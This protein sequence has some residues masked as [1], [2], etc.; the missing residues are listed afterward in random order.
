MDSARDIV[1]VIS[2]TFQLSDDAIAKR[3]GSSQPT[4]WRIRTGKTLDCSSGLY[5]ELCA[6]RNSLTPEPE[7]AVAR[8]D[9]LETI[10]AVRS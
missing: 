3:V 2:E 6:L 1:S 5:R 8:L 9:H 10:T 7:K 4:I